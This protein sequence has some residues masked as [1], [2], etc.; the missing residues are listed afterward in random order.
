MVVGFEGVEWLR[1]SVIV[2][3]GLQRLVGGAGLRRIMQTS[4]NVVVRG[5]V[6]RIVWLSFVAKSACG[7]CSSCLSGA[8]TLQLP[9]CDFSLIDSSHAN[10]PPFSCGAQSSQCGGS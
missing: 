7:N 1:S 9:H 5:R 4:P 2:K 8:S 3:S 6:L 10:A